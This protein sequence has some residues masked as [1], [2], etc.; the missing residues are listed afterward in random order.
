MYSGGRLWK[1][2]L[3]GYGVFVILGCNTPLLLESYRATTSRN[4]DAETLLPCH[5]VVGVAYVHD[6][7]YGR[8]LE[9]LDD[10]LF[11]TRI[12]DIV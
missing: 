8:A 11:T 7:M 1:E 12:L 10:G 9:E 2:D 5:T 3:E 6:Y 4:G